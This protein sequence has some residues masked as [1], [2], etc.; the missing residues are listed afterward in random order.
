M[1]GLSGV[2]TVRAMS[3]ALWCTI[4]DIMAWPR[5]GHWGACAQPEIFAPLVEELGK[6]MAQEL[7]LGP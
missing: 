1:W 2:R 3:E 6:G 7:N 4:H 5:F